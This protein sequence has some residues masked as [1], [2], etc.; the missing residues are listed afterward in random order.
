MNKKRREKQS[1]Q[2]KNSDDTAVDGLFCRFSLEMQCSRE[3]VKDV[4]TDEGLRVKVCSEWV[5]G[6][7]AEGEKGLFAA[8]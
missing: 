6:W 8:V 2:K 4:R 5:M 3:R 1:M 7:D